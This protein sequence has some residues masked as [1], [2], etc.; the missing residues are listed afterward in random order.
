MENVTL[1]PVPRI[2][3]ADG[4]ATVPFRSALG[5]EDSLDELAPIEL[6]EERASFLL[7]LD[8][9]VVLLDCAVGKPLSVSAVAETLDHVLAETAGEAEEEDTAASFET[10]EEDHELVVPVLEGDRVD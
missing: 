8:A 4:L 7:A 6:D 10:D 5:I 3:G 1:P 9:V 2:T